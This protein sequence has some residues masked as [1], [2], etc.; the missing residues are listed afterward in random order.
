M[1]QHLKRESM[2]LDE[3]ICPEPSHSTR[4]SK[5]QEL[6]VT[7]CGKLQ[8]NANKMLRPVMMFLGMAAGCCR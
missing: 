4:I 6:S 7:I 2:K 3:M 8:T 5:T 1:P